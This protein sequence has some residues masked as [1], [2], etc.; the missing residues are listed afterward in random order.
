M[1]PAYR[2]ISSTTVVVRQGSR[3]TLQTLDP[4]SVLFP[5]SATDAAGMVEATCDGDQVRIFAR[6]LDERSEQVEAQEDQ[7]LD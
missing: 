4:G 1:M 7:H 2:I 6:D 5:T 3:E